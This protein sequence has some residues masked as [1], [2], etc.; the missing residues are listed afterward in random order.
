MFSEA[1]KEKI[2]LRV[3]LMTIVTPVLAIFPF[4]FAADLFSLSGAT[5]WAVYAVGL[6]V[7]TALLC[8][9]VNWQPLDG[10]GA[11]ESKLRRGLEQQ[12]FP[13]SRGL[14]V[15]LGPHPEPRVYD[16][17]SFW[18]IGLLFLTGDDAY[19]V[20]ERARFRLRRA[21]I[22]RVDSRSRGPARLSHRAA[23]I[24]WRADGR[25]GGFSLQGAR[26]Q[27]RYLFVEERFLTSLKHWQG[28][29]KHDPTA[30]VR[31]TQE[32]IVPGVLSELSAPDL[33]DVASTAPYS[34]LGPK[35]FL[36]EMAASGMCALVVSI[37]TARPV[38]FGATPDSSGLDVVA[39]AMTAT[40]LSLLLK[41]KES[42]APATL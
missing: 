8:L 37:L 20:G 23:C 22:L 7:A 33:P 11:L 24:R 10:A 27:L 31:S 34:K 9:L 40:T 12:G 41:L 5:R 36:T 35:A 28:G 21:E 15:G 13:V 32:W 29:T 14:F 2:F 38:G 42:R 30:H 18:D 1:V 25:E 17:L 16:G 39:L 26:S 3:A 6:I 19:F 4:K